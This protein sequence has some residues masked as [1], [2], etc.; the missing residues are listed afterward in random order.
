VCAGIADY[1]GADV[2]LVRL[3]WVVVSIVPGCLV[4]GLI[5][6]VAA[7]ILMPNQAKAEA[8]SGPAR[9]MRSATDYKI[10]GVCGGLAEFFNT[11]DFLFRISDSEQYGGGFSGFV[12]SQ[13]N[14]RVVG[15]LKM[16]CNMQCLAPWSSKQFYGLVES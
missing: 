11:F 4:G 10:G 12:P 9:L 7:A 14:T 1:F 6:Y 16:M 13:L 5:A 8:P 3:L 2:T 15:Q